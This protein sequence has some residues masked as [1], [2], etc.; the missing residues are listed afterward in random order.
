MD[1]LA[2]HGGRFL[3]ILPRTRT[4]DAAG[5]AWLARGP[6]PFVEVARRPGRRKA[7]PDE[8]YWAVPAPTCSEEGYRVV[9]VR[10]SSKR[11]HDSA[12]R[13]DHIETATAALAELA[14]SLGSPRC[15]LRSRVAVEDA[16]T[17]A[18][19]A[20]QAARWVR[21]EVAEEV[22]ADY[23]QERRGRPG[24]TTRYRRVDHRRFSL[25]WSTDAAQVATDAASDGCFPLVTNDQHLTA[26]ELLAAYKA[27]PHLEQ[28][29]RVERGVVACTTGRQDHE[30]WG[31]LAEHLCHTT[32]VGE[33]LV[34]EPLQD[35]GLARRSRPPSGCLGLASSAPSRLL[36]V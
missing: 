26:T 19:A 35:M 16:A 6:I 36:L 3:S 33:A 21:V 9:W 29:L 27:Q 28:V 5:R 18:V 23:R 25:S 11:A 30:A 4:E 1:H 20:A 22:A 17:A 13:A 32:C 2:C 14:A 15:R 24:P 8:V 7:D 10:S 12:V 31:A 34:Q